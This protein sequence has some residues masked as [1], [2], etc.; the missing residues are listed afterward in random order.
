LLAV[1]NGKISPTKIELVKRY[2]AVLDQEVDRAAL[3]KKAQ[4]F[5][6]PL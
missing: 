4:Q 6:T 3:E 5:D 1:T 2:L